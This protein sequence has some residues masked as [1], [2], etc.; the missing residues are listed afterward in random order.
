MKKQLLALGILATGAG[1][2]WVLYSSSNAASCANAGTSR[3]RTTQIETLCQTR[4]ERTAL[5]QRVRELRHELFLK[6]QIAT[7]AD[8][9]LLTSA[10]TSLSPAAS[11]KLM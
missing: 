6:E 11:E 4:S 3:A 10:A 9:S 5:E 8:A 1:L 7:G 2:F